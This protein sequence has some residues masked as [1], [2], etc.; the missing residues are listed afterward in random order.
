[1]DA[2]KDVDVRLLD[3]TG[4]TIRTMQPGVEFVRILSPHTYF[5]AVRVRREAASYRL[6]ALIRDVTTTGLT[7]N[8]ASTTAHV[9]PGDSVSLRTTTD[10]RPGGGSTRV[11][12]DFFDIATR[13]WVFRHT[14]TVAP[15]STISFTPTAVGRWRV[16]ATYGGSHDSSP[17]RTDYRWIGV[18]PLTEL[19][20]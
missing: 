8:G 17:S 1:V 2:N 13:A 7:V 20:L 9:K 19:D 5:V 10:P 16:R 11:Q 18:A 6:H 3:A 12:A 14:W 4:N 15:G